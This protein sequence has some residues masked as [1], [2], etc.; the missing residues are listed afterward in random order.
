MRHC[1]SLEH[2]L[3]L[4]YAPCFEMIYR[5]NTNDMD[6]TDENKN[7][8]DWNKKDDVYWYMGYAS[9]TGSLLKG[10]RCFARDHKK[11]LRVGE[12]PYEAW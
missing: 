1:D 6:L 9:N 12:G 2:I 4:I 7:F 3:P 10:L 11:Y 5:G 8:T